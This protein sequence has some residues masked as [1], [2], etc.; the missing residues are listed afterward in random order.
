VKLLGIGLPRTGNT[1]LGEFLRLQGFRVGQYAIVKE[2]WCECDAIVDYPMQIMF[3]WLMSV[4]PD[5]KAILTTRDD[6]EDL[7]RST[8]EFLIHMK[9]TSSPDRVNEMLNVTRAIY[10][11]EYPTL[12]DIVAASDRVEESAAPFVKKGRV[13]RLPL[14]HGDKAAAVCHFLGIPDVGIDYPHEG[15]IKQ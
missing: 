6:L 4:D 13:M 12:G 8:T 11:R 3:P 7:H 15:R 10:G 9:E 14:H 2:V 1:S 5:I